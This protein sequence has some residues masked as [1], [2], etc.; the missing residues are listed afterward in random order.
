MAA[1]CLPA[2][3]LQWSTYPRRFLIYLQEEEDDPSEFTDYWSASRVSPSVS[4]ST[5]T[6][7]QSHSAIE[8]SSSSSAT[9]ARR[10]R[11]TGAII[12]G[13]LGSITF[14]SALFFAIFFWRRYKQRKFWKKSQIPHQEEA[15]SS[16]VPVLS[17]ETPTTDRFNAP[18]ISQDS[19]DEA[20]VRGERE[21]LEQLEST[22]ELLLNE[23]R[24][25]NAS[26]MQDPPPDYDSSNLSTDSNS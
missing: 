12:G 17:P 20:E 25:N 6:K 8:T 11:N 14:I 9:S 2:H 16:S 10:S 13:V 22:V 18:S 24:R 21:R 7:T 15:S 1:S 3:P 5:I 23:W 19:H 4:L 26:E